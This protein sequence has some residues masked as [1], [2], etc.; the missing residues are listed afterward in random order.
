MPKGTGQSDEPEAHAAYRARFEQLYSQL[1][2]MARRELA[3]TPRGTLCTTALVH[4]VFLKLDGA[5]L[6]VGERGRFMA[7]AGRTMRHVLIDHL[8]SRKAGKRGGD[9][10]RITL[11][12]DVPGAEP[13]SL[14]DLQDLEDGLNALEAIDPRLVAV[15]ECRFYGGMDFDEIACHLQV[16]ESTVYRDWRTAR[17]FLQSRLGDAP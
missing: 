7:L 2:L 11:I 15:V 4:E 14:L 12:T 3:S 9:L 16:S 5:A 6:D 10:V 13:Q 17:A 1:R 8:R